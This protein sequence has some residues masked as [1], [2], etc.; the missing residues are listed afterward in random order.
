LFDGPGLAD[1]RSVEAHEVGCLA[2][3][4]REITFIAAQLRRD[5]VGKS[6]K[7]FLH[8]DRSAAAENLRGGEQARR[9]SMPHADSLIGFALAA[10]RRAEDGNRGG[11]AET[12]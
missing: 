5:S 11:I 1:R 9:R 10:G 7:L 8:G 4:A 2:R 6:I 12:F 3:E